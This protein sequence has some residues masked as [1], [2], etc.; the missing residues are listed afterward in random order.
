MRNLLSHRQ[1]NMN[2]IYGMILWTLQSLREQQATRGISR[3]ILTA[4]S[5]EMPLVIR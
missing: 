4:E 2:N 3:V 1:P 5:Q